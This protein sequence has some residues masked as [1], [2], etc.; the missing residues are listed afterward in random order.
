MNIK[1]HCQ[2]LLDKEHGKQDAKLRYRIKWHGNIIAFNIGYRVEVE[3]WS[4]ETQRCKNNT[5]HGKKKIAASIINREIQ[6]FE[7]AVENVFFAFER[8]NKIPDKNEFRNKFNIETGRKTNEKISFFDI[9][10]EFIE[11]VGQQYSWTITT[12]SRYSSLKTHLQTF[13]PELS[14]ENITDETL[15]NFISYLQSKQ[16]MQIRYKKSQTGLRNVTVQS[17]IKNLKRF[18]KWAKN[19]GYYAGNI[20][21]SFNPRMKGT[22]DIKEIIYLSWEELMRLYNYEFNSDHMDRIRDVFCFCC[23]TSLRYSDMSKLKRSDIKNSY[24]RVITKKTVEGLKIELNKYSQAILDKYK[25][26]HFEDDRALPF[27]TLNEINEKIKIIGKI[28]GFN[29]PV[30][31][32]FFI[33]SQRYEETYPKYEL[34]STHCGR[35]TF[36]VNSIYLGIPAEVVMSWT[37]HEDYKS[38]KP[39]LKIVDELKRKSMNKFNEQ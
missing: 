22:G 6:Q 1:R 19:K 37:G 12:R 32:V 38:M 35:R 18:L 20:H 36:I 21:E 3:K 2:F 29:E 13:N 5:S 26:T 23:F 10:N 7:T 8:I 16:A 9:F 30:R 17:K 14:F 11:K 28:V 31:E 33:G 24:I 27:F 34:L 39:Y 25:N 4:S 15:S